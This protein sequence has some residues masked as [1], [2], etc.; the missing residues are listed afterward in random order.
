MNVDRYNEASKDVTTG[1]VDTADTFK[2]W[3]AGLKQKGSYI[4]YKDVDFSKV[5]NRAYAIAAV[6]A[7]KNTK[8]T[9]H[10][11]SPKGKVIADFTVTVVTEGRFRR[12]YSGHWLAVTSTLK[13]IPNGV[14]DICVV[15]DADG[16]DIELD[17]LPVFSQ[18]TKRVAVDEADDWALRPENEKEVK[19]ELS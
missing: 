7:N 18:P 17:D 2:G 4:I 16:F 19:F 12:D 1:F 8:F 9:I 10:E 14:T 5:K 3:Y 6:R 11:K 13:Y 15:A